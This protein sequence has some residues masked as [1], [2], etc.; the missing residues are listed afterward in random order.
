MKNIF[1]ILSS[2]GIEIPEGKKP[3]LTKAFAENY[4]TVAEFD[5][6]KNRLEVERDNYKDSLETARNTLKGFEGVNVDE[7]KGKIDQLTS[8]LISK[9]AEYQEKISDMEFTAVLDNAIASS[10]AR[11]A[12]ALKALLDVDALKASKNRSDDIRSAIET[13]K[14]ENDYL[15]VSAEPFANP[16][17]PTSSPNPNKKMTLSEAMAYKN[18][19][20]NADINTLI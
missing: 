19:N 1:E 14:K 13:A 17:A 10:G 2:Q 4:K 20:P 6:V 15:F 16:V 5:R 7:L 18:A 8:D 3:E 12:K 11:N 9:E